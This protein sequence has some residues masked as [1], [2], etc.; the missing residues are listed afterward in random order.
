MRIV[1]D[2]VPVFMDTTTYTLYYSLKA[3]S[4]QNKL[5]GLNSPK[6]FFLFFVI[7]IIP[8]K[9]VFKFSSCLLFKF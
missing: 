3:Q 5:L 7:D 4:L 9:N 1:T 2:D 8:V 6:V